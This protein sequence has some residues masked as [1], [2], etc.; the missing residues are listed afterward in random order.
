M[1]CGVSTP[2]SELI[3]ALAD[4]LRVPGV[5]TN[6][7]CAKKS[8]EVRR[9]R[10]HLLES[11]LHRVAERQFGVTAVE[12]RR[13]A[14]ATLKV[15]TSR[16][17]GRTLPDLAIHCDNRVHFVELKS[18]RVDYPRDD[19]VC[20]GAIKSFLHEHGHT[21]SAP[22]EVEQ[23]LIKLACYP[24]LSPRVGT[25]VLVMIDA[26][27]D[28]SRSWSTFLKDPD[29]WR[30]RMRTT[31]VQGW[32]TQTCQNVTVLPIVDVA[33]WARLIVCPV[34]PWLPSSTHGPSSLPS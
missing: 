29:Q 32:A 20:E 4:E 3:I 26:Y 30:A 5:L 8:D 34:P 31:F 9:V 24:Q 18:N 15:T 11:L 12:L 10:E 23:D 22:S 17:P 14:S 28:A 25:C 2:I 19:N 7:C 16:F 21:G 6:L 33:L 13:T 27:A 1:F